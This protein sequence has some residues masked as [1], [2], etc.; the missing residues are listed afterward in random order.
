MRPRASMPVVRDAPYYKMD[1]K[2]RG[3]AIILVYDKFDDTNLQVSYVSLTIVIVDIN[4]QVSYASLNTSITNDTNLQ[5][6]IASL[7]IIIP[8]YTIL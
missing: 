6:S 8:E 7:N 3:Q 2:K 5:V 1:H 4:I